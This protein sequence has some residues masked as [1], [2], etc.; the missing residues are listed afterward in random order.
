MDRLIHK[1]HKRYLFYRIYCIIVTIVW[2]VVGLY[3]FSIKT[4]KEFFSTEI[5]I[6]IPFVIPAMLMIA[7]LVVFRFPY[8]IFGELER[9]NQPTNKQI[10]SSTLTGGSIGWFWASF[11]FFSWYLHKDGIRF[12]IIGVGRGFVHF[13]DIEDLKVGFILGYTVNH[14]S[15]EVRSPIVLSSKKFFDRVKSQYERYQLGIK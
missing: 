10:T 3:E 15:N 7:N 4:T 8:S 11:P 5:L 14:K 9:T 1:K 12:F 13:K 2:N 6:L